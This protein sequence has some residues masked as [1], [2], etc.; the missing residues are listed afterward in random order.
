MLKNLEPPLASLASGGSFSLPKIEEEVLKFWKLNGIFEKSVSRRSAKTFV[1][2]E[3]PP[4]ANGRPGFHHIL[5]R[6]FKDVICRYKTMQGFRV[7]RKG[8]W[9]THGLPVEIEVEK[10]LGLKSKK[11]I[12]R[13]GVE[14]FNEACRVSVWK[15]KDEWERLTD[16]MGFWLDMEH[17]Y[18]TYENSY[19]ESLWWILKEVHKKKLL[20][21][22]RKVVPWCPRCGTVLSSHELALGYREATDESVFVKFKLKPTN[23]KQQTTRIGSQEFKDVFILSWTTTPWTLPGNVALAVGEDIE[24]AVTEKSGETFIVATESPLGKQLGHVGIHFR[25]KDLVG[26]KYEPLFDVKPL[27]T[28]A[29]YQVYPANFVTTTD[30]T[31]VVH[32]AV[33]Y[34]EDDYQLGVQVGLP[35]HHTVDEQ[36][37]FTKDV[38][39]F[40]GRTVKHKDPAIEKETTESI[41]AA[42]EKKG[43]LLKRETIVHEYP[44]CWRCSTPLIYYARTSWFIR[45]SALR[46]KLL[47]ANKTVNW[48]PAHLKE[49][50][51][52]EWLREV[53]DW[54][55]S[56]ARYWG[57]PLP[58]W[59]CEQCAATEVL[60]SIAEVASKLPKSTNTYILVR[61]GEAESNVKGVLASWPESK[62]FHLTRTGRAAEERLAK[63][64]AKVRPDLIIAS[65]LTRTKETAAIVAAA[66]T[67]PVTYDERLREMGFG[68]LNGG[69][70]EPF[71]KLFPYTRARISQKPAGG[72]SFG[73]VRTRMHLFVRNCES[74]HQGK[75]IV[76][77]S[78]GDPLWQLRGVLEGWTMEDMLTEGTPGHAWY[79]KHGTLLTASCRPMPRNRFGELDLHRPYIDEVSYPCMRCR[80]SR[81]P[82]KRD[83]MMRRVPDVVDV[84]FDSGAMPFAQAHYPFINGQTVNNKQKI[85]YP[86][87]YISEA[88]DQTRG[89]FYTLLAVATLLGRPAPFR[90][91]I[92]LGLVLDKAGQK[93]SKS[94]GNIVDPWTMIEKH[95][96]DTVRW[97]FYT[98]N[99]PGEP[100]RFDERDLTTVSRELFGI[101]YNSFVFW[102]TYGNDKRQTTNDKRPEATHM[103]DR[104]ILARL[105]ET[106]RQATAALESYDPGSAARAVGEFTSDL[107]RWYIRR[108]RRRFSAFASGFG[109]QAV[110]RDYLEASQ[111]LGYVLTTVAKLLAPFT[112]FFAEALWQALGVTNNKQQT[113]NKRQTADS[114]HLQDWPM[115]NKR[116]TTNNKQ[117]IADMV[118]VRRIASA[119]LAAR[120]AASVKVRQPLTSLKVKSLKL[121]G[122]SELLD[123]LMD[124][125]NVKEIRF[126]A[127]LAAEVVLDTTITHE[128]R[129]EGRR[130]EFVRSVQELRQDAK[131]SPKD[132]IALAVE[133]PEELR[134]I[135]TR[136]TVLV[137][138]EVRASALTFGVPRRFDAEAATTIDGMPIRLWIAKSRR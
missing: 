60:G 91:I 123:V 47:A 21:E 96:V 135:L 44:F 92:S 48:V 57:T 103:L 136:D 29:A 75:R 120:S 70:V 116:Q 137:S 77:V 80:V 24:Y 8:G 94:K 10:Q 23:D 129:E 93:M 85:A 126:D 119:G 52:G 58:V 56:R 43:A 117:L 118:E 122:K 110:P 97:L 54:A 111:T 11:E 101:L 64:I 32:T 22:G 33:M 88:M 127:K 113:T 30:G 115:G 109:E 121:K 71:K 19:M 86:A 51:F 138:R 28:A 69:P 83:G 50:R 68:E 131:L 132:F 102:N 76:V 79:P 12:E 133:V 14:K 39:E 124:E 26:L 90:N 17:P 5:A 63:E 46:G 15:Y 31:G 20:F 104:W 65:D 53:K 78:H 25:G 100:K 98:M 99:Q 62:P 128:L 61:H 95:G 13:Y 41:I 7:P 89:W 84:W 125:V 27:Q 38:A 4:T 42:L 72:E 114:V 35:Q 40:T 34:G 9:D 73:D 45:M 55:I 112:P 105:N 107:S 108:S 18:V 37:R 1:F 59:R 67:A 87:D 81:D 36:A 106:I 16:R 74:R 66:C 2:Y 3:G 82:A 130:R 134:F 6:S 49:G